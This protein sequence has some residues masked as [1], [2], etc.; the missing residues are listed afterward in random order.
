MA[1]KF[2]E[3]KKYISRVVRL[4]ICFHDGHYDNYTMLSDVPEGKYDDLYVYGIG[5]ADVEFPLD[6][7]TEP[8]EA[9][10]GFSLADG[11]FLGCGLEVA[12]TEEPRDIIRAIEAELTFGDLRGYLQIGR[13]FSIVTKEGWSEENYEWRKDIPDIYNDLYVYGI[14]IEDNPS[15]DTLELGIVDSYHNKKLRVVVSEGPRE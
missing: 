2:G 5:M 4:S 15:S 1:I 13:H 7:Y 6:V 14:G 8:K 10:E 12:V 9:S 3:L 11:Y